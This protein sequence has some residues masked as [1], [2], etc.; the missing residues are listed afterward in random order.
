MEA[1]Q[2][3]LNHTEYE[4]AFFCPRTVCDG[5]SLDHA[6]LRRRDNESSESA[7]TRLALSA[8]AFD[9]HKLQCIDIQQRRH[10]AQQ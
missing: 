8:L 6:R 9:G 7:P 4:G 3:W 1:Q 5:E 10:R 2:L